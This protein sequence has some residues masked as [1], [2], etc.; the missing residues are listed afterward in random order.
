MAPVKV[1]SLLIVAH[2][3][4]VLVAGIAAVFGIRSILVSGPILALTGIL[5]AVLSYRKRCRIGFYFGLT[6]PTVALA[7]FL[8]ICCLSWGPDYAH[9]PVSLFLIVFAL[10]NIPG[11][12]FCISELLTAHT[13]AQHRFQFSIRTLLAITF[14]VAL[15]LGILRSLD[16]FGRL[17]SVWSGGHIR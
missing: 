15:Y 9:L 8:I 11:C 7:W 10:G 3:L 16:V 1:R 4:G 6:A 2:T 5:I 13:G 12:V 17:L 14:F